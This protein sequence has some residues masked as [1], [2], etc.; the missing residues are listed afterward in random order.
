MSSTDLL[1]TAEL[2]DLLHASERTVIRWRM[3][4][5]GPAWIKAG[6]RVLYRR[7]DVDRWLDANKCEPAREQREG[8]A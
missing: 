2:A 4:R 5:T 6:G 3:Q 7:G 1:D 8:A